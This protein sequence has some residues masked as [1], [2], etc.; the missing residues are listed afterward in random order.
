MGRGG[1]YIFLS[2]SSKDTAMVR[3]IRNEFEL[4]GQNPIAFHLKCL[5]SCY[6]GKNEEL[7][8]LI[9]RE[10]DARDWFVYCTCLNG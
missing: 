10:I 9:Y 6:Q 8:N 3:K 1:C 2:H 4:C 5:A 7:R